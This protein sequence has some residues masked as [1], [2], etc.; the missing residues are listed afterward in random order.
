LFAKIVKKNQLCNFLYIFRI[1]LNGT[2]VNRF[3]II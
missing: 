1:R 2:R 3:S